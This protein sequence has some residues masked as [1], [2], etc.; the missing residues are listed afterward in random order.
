MV[1]I[2]GLAALVAIV[3]I[4]AVVLAATIGP[5]VAYFVWG[6]KVALG[7]FF[8]ST[9]LGALIQIGKAFASSDE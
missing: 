2:K 4:M 6:W 5:A 7:W 8:I 9:G 1:V 3:L